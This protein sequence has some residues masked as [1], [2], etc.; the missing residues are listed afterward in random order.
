MATRN[1]V[2]PPHLEQVIQ[3]LVQSG[4]YQN[5]SEVTREGLRLLEQRVAEDTAKIEAL[6]Q[7]ISSGIMDLEHG[8]FTQ[9]NEGDLEH[10]LDGLSLEAA[11]PA[12]QK[13]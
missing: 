3:D 13:H 12:R 7:A 2:L 10:F 6:R 11:L 9:V 8:R 1:V 4:R 5:A